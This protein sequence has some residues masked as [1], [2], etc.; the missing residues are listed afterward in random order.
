MQ[1][2]DCH[3]KLAEQFE[4]AGLWYGHGTDNAADEAWWLMHYVL[5]GAEE[6]HDISADDK[7]S[8]EQLEYIESLARERI[9]SRKPLAYLM[10]HAWFCGLPFDVS[11]DVLVPRS[12]IAELI[13]NRF[14]PLISEPPRRILDLCTGS[15]C[16]GIAAAFAFPEAEVVI[17]DISTPALDIARRNILRHDLTDRVQAVT[18]DLFKH[19]E[20]KFDLILTNPPYVSDVEY[21]DLPDEFHLEPELGLV[22]GQD[23]LEIPLTIINESFRYLTEQGLLILEVGNNWQLLDSKRPDISFLWLEFSEGGEGVCALTAS[24][25]AAA[26][27]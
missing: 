9:Q 16:I 20:G 27:S 25:L 22:T 3:Q 10:R 19:I 5:H 8:P 14:D 13:T 17:S 18:S 26:S 4:D 7:I 24:Q 15:G 6:L 12:P 23:G 11:E 2:S 1:A 21:A